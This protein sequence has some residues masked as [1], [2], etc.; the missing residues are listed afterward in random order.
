MEHTHIMSIEDTIGTQDDTPACVLCGKNVQGD[1]GFARINHG[2]IMVNL[3]C[4]HCLETFQKD[5]EPYMAKLS[6]IESYRALKQEK[7]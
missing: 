2:G 3:C 5:P 1:R 6:K 4:P 7:K